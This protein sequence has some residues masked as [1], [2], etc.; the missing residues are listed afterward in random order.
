MLNKSK[1]IKTAFAMSSISL[2]IIAAIFLFLKFGSYNNKVVALV[3]NE[4]IYENEIKDELVDMFPN[5]DPRTFEVEKLPDSVLELMAKG[6]YVK[7]QIYQNAKNA[8][9]DK[10]KIVKEQIDKY[11]RR[12]ISEYY[13]T[14]I[15][16]KKINNRAL[17]DKY[18]ELADNA[19]ENKQ[20]KISAIL[21]PSQELANEVIA[22]L[23]ANESFTRLVQKYSLDKEAKDGDLGYFTVKNIKKEFTI[24]ESMQNG[25]ISQPIRTTDGWYVI[26]LTD[27]KILELEDFS[28]MQNKLVEEIKKEEINAIFSK[29]TK[30]IDIKIL[31]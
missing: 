7:K 9:I 8:K 27:V 21:L 20:Y 26:Q 11:S 6:I 25:D 23:K 31:I 30:N 15:V 13:L 16:N 18:A 19:E 12:V 1:R 5:S 14:S 29:I 4:R 24:V 17:S 28:V 22:K 2:V 10:D 3:N